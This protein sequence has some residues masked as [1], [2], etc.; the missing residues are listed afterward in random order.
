MLSAYEVEEEAFSRGLLFKV[1]LPLRLARA[2]A[3]PSPR[4]VMR[5]MRMH[6]KKGIH[7]ILDLVF[8]AWRARGEAS[9]AL[10]GSV[11]GRG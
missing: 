6:F 2:R 1:W 4:E 5:L 11:R 3:P 9:R 7:E 8:D 10:R